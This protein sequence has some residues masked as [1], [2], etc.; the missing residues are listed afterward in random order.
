VVTIKEVR[1]RDELMIISQSGQ[2]IR[3]KIRQVSVLGRATQGVRLIHLDEGDRV[4][5]VTTIISSED[6]DTTLEA[7]GGGG[8]RSAMT[9]PLDG[10]KTPLG[11]SSQTMDSDIGESEEGDRT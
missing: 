7:V 10:S 11:D 4:V 3:L 8:D 1:E 5:D 9:P 6:S 2:V